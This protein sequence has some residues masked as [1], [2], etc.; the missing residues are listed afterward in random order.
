VKAFVFMFLLILPGGE[1]KVESR[2]VTE[3]PDNEQ[4]EYLFNDMKSEGEIVDWGAICVA[5][6]TKG[7]I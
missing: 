4:V 6:Q 3:C 5:F 7:A 2:L 1:A